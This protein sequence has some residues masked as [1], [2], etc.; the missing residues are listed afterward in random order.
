[1]KRTSRGRDDPSV[2]RDYPHHCA[3]TNIT[4]LARQ[5]HNHADTP[6]RPL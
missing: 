5:P 6:R 1:M 2:A 3:G 4:T